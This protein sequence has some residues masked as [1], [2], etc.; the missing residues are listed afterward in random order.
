MRERHFRGH[1]DGEPH[2]CEE[3]ERNRR[4]EFLSDIGTY[5]YHRLRDIALQNFEGDTRRIEA[6]LPLIADK[7]TRRKIQMRTKKR[8]GMKLKPLGSSV[9]SVRRASTCADTASAVV[10]TIYT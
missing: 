8:S 6:F 5:I 4:E 2:L 10:S 1:A 7:P 9:S 3:Y